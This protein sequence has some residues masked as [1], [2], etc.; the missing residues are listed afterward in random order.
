M[1][2]IERVVLGSAAYFILC[3]G[4]GVAAHI[5]PGPWDW[6]IGV[7]L[8][9]LAVLGAGTLGGLAAFARRRRA[10]DNTGGRRRR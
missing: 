4:Y 5:I 3:T 2:L 8:T 10:D 1:S 9:V 7:G 6:R